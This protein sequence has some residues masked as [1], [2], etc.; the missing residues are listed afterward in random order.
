MG[1]EDKRFFSEDM[2]GK[3]AGLTFDMAC[4]VLE[5]GELTLR[6]ALELCA[7]LRDFFMELF[8]RQEEVFDSLMAVRLR[9]II[10]EVYD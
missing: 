6:E 4:L 5:Q 8:P 1:K 10:H 7:N 2:I 3:R 9:Q